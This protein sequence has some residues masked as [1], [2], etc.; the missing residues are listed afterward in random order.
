MPNV[1]GYKKELD[2][3]N[4]EIDVRSRPCILPGLVFPA[5]TAATNH[6]ACRR[7]RWRRSC[8]ARVSTFPPAFAQAL[9]DLRALTVLPSVARRAR[10]GRG[11]GGGGAAAAE[12]R[13][14]PWPG[15]L[16]LNRSELLSLTF[17]HPDHGST[18]RNTKT[19]EHC[20]RRHATTENGGGGAAAGAVGRAVR[21]QGPSFPPARWDGHG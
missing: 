7:R 11:Q 3:V 19:N 20:S 4:K 16:A 8:P 6:E 1:Q 10:K 2:V 13:G 9:C 5:G 15:W 14:G 17:T 18:H 12:V 21:G